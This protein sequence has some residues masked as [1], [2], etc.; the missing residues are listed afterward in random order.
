MSC[1][2]KID[3]S[4]LGVISAAFSLIGSILAF[5]LALDVLSDEKTKK[6]D[7]KDAINQQIQDLNQQLVLL[8]RK[9]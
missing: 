3:P 6:D 1:C 4:L 9:R 2:K 5:I 7:A 8:E